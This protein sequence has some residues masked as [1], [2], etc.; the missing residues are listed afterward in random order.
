[1]RLSLSSVSF[2]FLSC[3]IAAA[4]ADPTAL[5]KPSSQITVQGGGIFTRAVTDSGVRYKPTSA[6]SFG[7]GYRFYVIRW[8]GVEGDFDYFRNSQKYTTSTL[9]YAQKTNVAAVSGGAV[10]N[11]PNPMTKKFESFFMVGGG[12]LIFHP[13]GTDSN[14]ETKNAIVFGGGIDVPVSRHLALRAQSK[15]FLYKAPDF[16]LTE[17]KV[18]KFSQAMIPS[19]G[20]VYKF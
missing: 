2:F 16:G 11:I 13:E 10:F 9:T 4:Q 6:G 3:G 17:L 5:I 12:A 14:F 15:T 18:N 20:I 8:L 7:A 1:M 19:A